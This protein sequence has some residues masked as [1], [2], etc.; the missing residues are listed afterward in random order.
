MP[1]LTKKYNMLKQHKKGSN[2]S[3]PSCTYTKKPNP[4]CKDCP[5]RPP[6]SL[7]PSSSRSLSRSSSS[8]LINS[9]KGLLKNVPKQVKTNNKLKKIL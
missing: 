7:T 4:L 2:I 1:F 9:S 8:S 3:P 6:K 5:H